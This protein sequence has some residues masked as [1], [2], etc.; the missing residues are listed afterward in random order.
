M[1]NVIIF[2]RQFPKYHPHAG[3]P[4][5]FPEKIWKW[6]YDK[7]NGDVRDLLYYTDSFDEAFGVQNLHNVHQ[8][9]PKL[10][11]IRL[12][13]RWKVGDK[14]SPRVWSCVPYH[15]PQLEFC[16]DITVRDV[17]SFTKDLI[18]DCFYING[19]EVLPHVFDAIAK[20]D[21]LTPSELRSWL[22]YPKSFNGQ[23]ISWATKSPIDDLIK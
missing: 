1:S 7:H 6:Y 19:K 16:P 13:N 8:F 23:I 14:F 5:Y 4:T 11:T 18:S 22:K 17:Y 3:Q 15:S 2:S 12:G 9:A 21:G 10:T 20:N